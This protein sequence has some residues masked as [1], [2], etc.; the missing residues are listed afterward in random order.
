VEQ[1]YNRARD[2]CQRLGETPQ[3]FRVLRGLWGVYIQWPELQRARELSEQLLNLAQSMQ[4]T[5]LLLLAHYAVGITLFYLGAL[6]PAR[7]H[8]EQ[9]I[10]LYD[11]Q[12]HHSLTLLYNGSDSGMACRAIRAQI[13]WLC[14]YPEQALRGMLEALTLA[15]QLSHPFSLVWALN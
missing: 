6:A 1:T 4:D 12:Q 9:G 3:L 13:L 8:L 14:G 7:E 10:A 11:D 5:A 2:L 15:Q